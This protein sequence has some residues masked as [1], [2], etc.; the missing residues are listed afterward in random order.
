MMAT[1]IPVQPPTAPPSLPEVRL[2]Q[3]GQTAVPQGHGTGWTPARRA[4]PMM[5]QRVAQPAR[6]TLSGKRVG[7]GEAQLWARGSDIT[8]SILT[9]LAAVVSGLGLIIEFGK[10]EP[11]RRGATVAP[12]PT[13]VPRPVPVA[14]TGRPAR[15]IWYVIGGAVSLLGI[16]NIWASINRAAALQPT[17]VPV[18]TTPG[19]TAQ[20]GQ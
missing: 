13:G 12:T 5:A 9:G 19:A 11:A 3:P 8:F 7:Q 16:A 20:T 6:S 15:P 14:V 1:G 17:T 10:G 4:A 2:A 18:A